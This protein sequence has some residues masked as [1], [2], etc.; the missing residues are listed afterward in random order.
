M[1]PVPNHSH[2]MIR[3][4]PWLDYEYQETRDPGNGE[5]EVIVLHVWVN[6]L[7]KGYIAAEEYFADGLPYPDPP[8]MWQGE[9]GSLG[10]S[11]N[12]FYGLDDP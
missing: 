9:K 11:S 1:Y 6:D 4:F 5:V 7:G 12:P 3:Y 8:E 10:D 2:L